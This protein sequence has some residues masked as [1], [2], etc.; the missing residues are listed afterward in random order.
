VTCSKWG[1]RS[2]WSEA[3]ATVAREAREGAGLSRNELAVRVGV[4]RD[5][6]GRIESASFESKL[7][8]IATYAHGLDL[9]A[10]ELIEAAERL[11]VP[12]CC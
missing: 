2:A 8:A 1:R 9:S 4:G 10:W 6:I 7:S 12:D 3:V 11:L 5:F